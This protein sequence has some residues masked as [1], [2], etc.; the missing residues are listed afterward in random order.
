[1]SRTKWKKPDSTQKK[2]EYVDAPVIK[3]LPMTLEC[4]LISYDEEE[5]YMFGEVVNVSADES[6]L[7][8][9]GQ[10]DPMKLRPIMFDGVHGTYHVLGEKVGKAF[11]DGAKLK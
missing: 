6:I 3:E 4:K 10:I 7:D 1:M 2:S 11:S 5:H 9:N 8:E